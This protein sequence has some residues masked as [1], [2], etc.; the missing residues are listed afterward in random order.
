MRLVTVEGSGGMG[1][2]AGIRRRINLLLLKDIKIGDY[3]IVH[4]G[5]AIEKLDEEAALETLK[6]MEEIGKKY[7]V[8]DRVP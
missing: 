1:E 8:H 3:V 2:L 5:Y 7:E 6:I 4:A